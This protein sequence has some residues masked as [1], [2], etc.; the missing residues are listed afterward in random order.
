MHGDDNADDGGEDNDRADE[1]RRH[2]ICE[3]PS[4]LTHMQLKSQ[5]PVAGRGRDGTAERASK[6]YHTRYAV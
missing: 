6:G 2:D 4:E 1:K 3:Q 5:G